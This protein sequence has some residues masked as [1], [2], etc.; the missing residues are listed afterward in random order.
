VEGSACCGVANIEAGILCNSF[1][2]RVCQNVTKYVF[3]DSIHPTERAYS[4]L[5]TNIVENNIH[6]FV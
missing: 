2:L 4:M 3:W 5:V 6:K 1:S